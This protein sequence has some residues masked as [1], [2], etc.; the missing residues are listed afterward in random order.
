MNISELRSGQEKVEIEAVI[1]GM[2]EP[3]P[4]VEAETPVLV[5]EIALLPLVVIPV[6]RLTLKTELGVRLKPIP[7][8]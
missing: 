5:N 7:A 2:E 8:A 6:P 1:T 4:Y 3:A